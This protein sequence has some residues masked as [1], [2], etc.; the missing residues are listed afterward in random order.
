M[1]NSDP[2]QNNPLSPYYPSDMPSIRGNGRK[3]FA[4]LITLGTVGLFVL[5]FLLQMLK[6]IL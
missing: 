4:I 3:W 1:D 5:F 2:N 6:Y